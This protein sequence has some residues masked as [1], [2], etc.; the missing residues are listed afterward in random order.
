MSGPW[1]SSVVSLPRPQWGPLRPQTRRPHTLGAKSDRWG[2]RGTLFP[3]DTARTTSRAPGRPCSYRRGSGREGRVGVGWAQVECRGD[4]SAGQGTRS[5]RLLRGRGTGV[6]KRQAGHLPPTS[7]TW[8]TRQTS[9]S[10]PAPTVFA[11][12][13][14][15][16]GRGELP[17]RKTLPVLQVFCRTRWDTGPWSPV[18]EGVARS[19]AVEARDRG[20]A[21]G[22]T[23][24]YRGRVGGRCVPVRVRLRP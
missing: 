8:L 6:R 10:T 11:S 22:R 24:G 23:G 2:S 18:A 15:W 5:H 3:S 9:R 20:S 4:G 7:C 1:G 13:S 17:P 19:G 12:A 16:L 14:T 21:G